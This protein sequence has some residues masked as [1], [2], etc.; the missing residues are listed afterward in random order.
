MTPL[1]L[2]DVKSPNVLITQEWTAKLGDFGS[3]RLRDT[4]RTMTRV[5]SPLWAAPEILR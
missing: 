2:S 5:G 3:S 1:S 4:L